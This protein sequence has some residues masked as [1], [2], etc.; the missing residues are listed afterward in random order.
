MPRRW[1]NLTVITS[2]SAVTLT[3]FGAAS[4]AS[5]AAAPGLAAPAPCSAGARTLSPHGAHLYPDT[6][7]GGYTSV[8]TDVD[9]V[10]N[11]GTNTFLPGN[12]VVLTDQATQCLTSFSLDFERTSANAKAGPDLSVRSVTVNG[13][14]AAFTF[15]RPAYPGDP[16][17]PGDPNP[18]AHEASQDN[19]VGGPQHNPL[20][21]ACSPELP[22]PDPARQDALNGTPCP[23]NKLVITP[24]A[25]VSNGATFTVRVDYTGRPGVHNDGDGTTEGWFRSGDGG[26][27]TTEP[28]GSEDWMPLNDYPT[29]KPTYDF[30]D[31]V[32]AGK[33]AL[34]NG[35]LESTRSNKPNPEF[36]NGSTTYHW[37]SRAPIASYLVEDSV[38]DYDLTERTAD[39]GTRYYEAQD[40]AI[41]AAQ[42][43]KNRAIMNQQENIT[44]FESQFSGTYPFTSDGVIVGTPSA[45]FEEEM[46]TMITFAGGQI[47]LSVFYHENMHQWWGDNVT[48]GGYDMTF[49]KEGMATLAQYLFAARQA[50]KAAGG[51][52]SA[53][54]QAAFQA[55]LVHQFKATY[56]SVGDFWTAAP[57]N[58]TPFGLFSGSSTYARP[59]A[60]YIALR[61]ILGSTDFTQ[62][63]QQVQRVYGGSHI[64]EAQWEAA[65]HRWMPNRSTACQAKLSEFFTQWFDTAYPAGGGIDRP[66]ITGPGLAG[67]GFYNSAGGCTLS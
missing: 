16:H 38:G 63:L 61:Q 49:Y 9:M 53:K 55:S 50:E 46:Q 35:V 29:A 36:P 43:A 34:A 54:G 23:A 4:P 59:A 18:L 10:Y 6:G 47:G 5:A 1:L 31:T 30:H 15:A 8:H 67:P 65:F 62:A 60:A 26:F 27:V 12:H 22:A 25:P 66:R 42:R 13:Q 17:G 32:N 56:G 39:N 11:A 48:E 7:N 44:E 45:S 3:A 41:P 33:M 14:P 52:A 2:I 58:P 37:H 57:S 40:A 24:A 51:P 28:V 19:P 64:T 21:P 20:P